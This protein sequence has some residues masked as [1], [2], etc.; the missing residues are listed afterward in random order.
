VRGA[1]P[2]GSVRFEKVMKLENR[3]GVRAAYSLGCIMSNIVQ[4]QSFD[5]DYVQRLINSD[6][7]TEDAFVAYFGELLSIKLRS[8]LRS[9]E[10][11][12]DVTQETFLRVLKTLRQSGI[13][14]PEALGAF[15]NSVCN[16]VLFEAY[17]SQRRATDPLVDYASDDATADTTILEEEERT[18]VRSVLSE[19]PEKDRKILRWLFFDERDKGEVCRVLQVDREY[20]RVLLHRAKQRFR[21]DYLRRI[22]TKPDRATPMG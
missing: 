15:V 20:L 7:A 19:L 3:R 18:Q 10:L 9:P 8:R 2:P 6:S 21:T 12:Q 13:E 17:R 1:F 22:A 5:A 16:N 4:R 11:I 14:T